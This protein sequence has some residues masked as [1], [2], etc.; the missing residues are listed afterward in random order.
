M[1]V[2]F[3][4]LISFSL[5]GLIFLLILILKPGSFTSFGLDLTPDKRGELF[6]MIVILIMVLTLIVTIIYSKQQ[7]NAGNNSTK[8]Q[9]DKM[10]EQIQ[11]F[12]EETENL[13]K[14]A[15]DQR[16]KEFLARMATLKTEL[17]VN[18]LICTT[19]I[20]GSY[21]KHKEE[22]SRPMP[23]SRFIYPM[24]SSILSSGEVIDEKTRIHLW[25][26]L[27]LMG[28]INSLLSQA[29]Q[30]LHA[31]HMANPRDQILASG[32]RKK[33]YSL[34]DSSGDLAH[35]LEKAFE[36]STNLLCD[37]KNP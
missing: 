4:V 13:I 5:I 16:K 35:E 8:Q 34:L 11:A 26:T 22:D 29:L 37:L 23:E 9:I 36:I 31:E 1:K 2:L 28:T 27:R 3:V 12:K 25:N 7:I 6:N 17:G 24:L 15:E 33:I 32:R 14:T 19:E 20:I 18:Q 10:Q 21:E 30:I